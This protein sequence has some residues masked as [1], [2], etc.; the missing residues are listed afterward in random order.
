MP[1]FTLK[2][3]EIEAFQMTEAARKDRKSWP[4]WLQ[5]AWEK[6]N[7][8]MGSIWP[9]NY[10]IETGEE[11][12]VMRVREGTAFVQWGD[13]IIRYPD[14]RLAHRKAEVFLDTFDGAEGHIE[15]PP[16][17]EQPPEPVPTI[18]GDRPMLPAD[19][20]AQLAAQRER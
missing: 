16:P 13:V 8:E 14:G 19:F 11:N 9:Q 2:P 7:A 20:E 4:D 3:V 18:Q 5:E 6:P 15:P 10:P 1:T 12:L 17:P